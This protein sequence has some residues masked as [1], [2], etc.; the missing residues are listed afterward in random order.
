MSLKK[1]IELSKITKLDSEGEKRLLEARKR[2]SAFDKKI[3]EQVKLK[4]VG[5]ELLMRT[6]SI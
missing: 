4:H 3:E 6:C 2:A 5:Q 1:L